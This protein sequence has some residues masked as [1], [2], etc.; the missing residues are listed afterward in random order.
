MAEPYEIITTHSDDAKDRQVW[1]YEESDNFNKL[2]EIHA[3]R[4]QILENALYD[5]LRFRAISTASGIQLDRLGEYYLVTRDGDSDNGY[6]SRIITEIARVQ[7]AGQVEP[8]LTSLR[9]LSNQ[10]DV[11]LLQLFP[12]T[13]IGYIYVDVFGDIADPDILAEIMDGVKAAGVKLDVAVQL[14]SSAFIFSDSI[15]GGVSGTGFA[16]QLD[17]S[18]GGTFARII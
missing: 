18:D 6:R 15:L 7:Q 11:S 14:K 16:T 10:S 5:L 8:I 4:M 2:I 12:A 17:G 13:L 9:T 1:Q 3:E